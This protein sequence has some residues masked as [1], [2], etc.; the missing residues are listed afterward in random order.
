MRRGG[1]ELQGQLTNWLFGGRRNFVGRNCDQ[2]KAWDAEAAIACTGIPLLCTELYS[3]SVTQLFFYLHCT[4]FCLIFPFP[5][6]SIYK[7]RESQ[8]DTLFPAVPAVLDPQAQKNPFEVIFGGIQAVFGHRGTKKTRLKNISSATHS[9]YGYIQ[10]HPNKVQGVWAVK[11]TQLNLQ[12]A[13]LYLPHSHLPTSHS[14]AKCS[15]L[16]AHLPF[17]VAKF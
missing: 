15:L 4:C 9:I 10:V 3:A 12:C 7:H 14:S 11:R 17:Y 16:C 8:D 2:G 13:V 6:S 1:K 5:Y